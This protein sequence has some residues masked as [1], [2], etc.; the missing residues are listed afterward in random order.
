MSIKH[1]VVTA[2]IVLVVLYIANN[3]PVVGNIV[4]Q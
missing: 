1:F 4:G 2:L 3:V